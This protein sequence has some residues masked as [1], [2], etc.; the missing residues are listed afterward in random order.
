MITLST[1]TPYLRGSASTVTGWDPTGTRTASGV[2]RAV[3]SALSTGST[4]V[5]PAHSR[6]TT[7]AT[8]T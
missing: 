5:T 6:L 8:T 1:P 2:T 3:V 7:G 4:T